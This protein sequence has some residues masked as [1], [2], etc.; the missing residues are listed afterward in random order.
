MAMPA[1]LS[2]AGSQKNS[3]GTP[4]PKMTPVTPTATKPAAA[5]VTL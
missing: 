2:S 5:H 1:A 4:V 3:D